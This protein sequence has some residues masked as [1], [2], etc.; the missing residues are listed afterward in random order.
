[1][2]TYLKIPNFRLKA[3]NKTKWRGFT[4]AEVLIT[5]AIIGVVAA[6]TIPT[7]MA[8]QEKQQYLTS[9]KKSYS[10]VNQA[11][12]QVAA[13]NGCVDDLKCTGLFNS[14]T[15]AASLGAALSPYFKIVKNCQTGQNQGC[16]ATKILANY[17]GS[18]EG[19]N[20]SIDNSNWYY[21]FITADGTSF[22]L[23]NYTISGASYYDCAHSGS[24]GRLGSKSPMTQMCGQVLMDVNGLKKPN[25]LG[26]DIFMFY[27]TNGK[28]ALLYPIGGTDDGNA[29][30]WINPGDGTLARCNPNDKNGM[31]CA[32][33][34]MEEGWQM[35][36]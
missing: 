27:I 18:P 21:K 30:W 36:Y 17:D 15:D 3:K 6:M 25:F 16:F 20:N 12:K 33:R 14:T 22:A 5:L 29:D 4:L 2:L 9:L 13:D 23:L 32:G 11:L 34:I 7:L 1:M 28:G 24:S 10:L 8:Q 26:R 19:G 35:N 31:Y